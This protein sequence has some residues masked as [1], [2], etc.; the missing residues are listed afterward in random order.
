MTDLL[1]LI[2]DSIHKSLGLSKDVIKKSLEFFPCD[3]YSGCTL[4]FLFILLIMV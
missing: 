3:K 2:P 1:D 4:D